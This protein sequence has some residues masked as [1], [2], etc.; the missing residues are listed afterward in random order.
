ML[1]RG[2]RTTSVVFMTMHRLISKVMRGRSGAMR[3]NANDTWRLI[4]VL[5]Y[6]ALMILDLLRSQP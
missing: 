2:S 5:L 3:W 6:L 1:V 4:I